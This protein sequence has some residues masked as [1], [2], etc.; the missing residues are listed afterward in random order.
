MVRVLDRPDGACTA[1]S[2]RC[3]PAPVLRSAQEITDRRGLSVARTR[4]AMGLLG[5]GPVGHVHCQAPA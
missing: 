3:H 4:V 5:C 2:I 1:S